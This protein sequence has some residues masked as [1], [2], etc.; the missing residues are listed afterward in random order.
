MIRMT[1]AQQIARIAHHMRMDASRLAFL[2]NTE[3]STVR[4]WLNRA[5][6]EDGDDSAPADQRE[7]APH[8]VA[9]VRALA[10]AYRA[11]PA[12]ISVIRHSPERFQ[13]TLDSVP[14]LRLLWEPTPMDSI[15]YDG[16]DDA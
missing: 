3:P 2:L 9:H 10:L 6:A 11:V 14:R 7:P 8:W 12:S 13:H 1:G 16:A 4:R 15:V 5:R